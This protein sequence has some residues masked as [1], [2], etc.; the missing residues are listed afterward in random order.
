MT[1]ARH[2]ATPPSP[3]SP[4]DIP[5]PAH[6]RR[7]HDRLRLHGRRPLAGLA[8]RPPLLRPAAAAG[9][10]RAGRPQR[11]PRSPTPPAGSAGRRPRP[12]G[13]ACSSATTSTSSTS[14][15]PATP[16]P[17]S[18]S[19]RSRPASTCCARSRWP[20]RSPRPRR[21]PR[22]PPAP[23][24][25]GVR[26]MVGLHLPPGAG[27]RAGPAAGRRGPAGRDP[28][29]A[30]AV[31][32]GLD[33]RPGRADVVA[34]GEGQGRLGRAGRHRRAHRRPDPVHHRPDR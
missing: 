17:R 31:P 10:H 13:G 23:R 5:R 9:A 25:K 12:T 27:D 15:P 16:T 32:A 33:R 1:R 29:R 34:A 18:P 3:G 24:R 28:A 11:R 30:R 2:P 26:S 20:T 21:W 7:R 14:A 22:P 6:P 19:P 4:H 8:H